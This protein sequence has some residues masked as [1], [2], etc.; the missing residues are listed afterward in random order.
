MVDSDS[1]LK[2]VQTRVFQVSDGLRVT[3]RRRRTPEA[4]PMEP[5]GQGRLV[6]GRQRLNGEPP[7]FRGLAQEVVWQDWVH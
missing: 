2:T 4:L 7:L 1:E 5:C 6:G 3:V